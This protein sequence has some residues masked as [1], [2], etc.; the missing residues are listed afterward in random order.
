MMA[1]DPSIWTIAGPALALGGVLIGLW[2][3]RR[4]EVKKQRLEFAN[5]QLRD[6]Y[7]PILAVRKR[8]RTLSEL[9]VE[10]TNVAQ[11]SSYEYPEAQSG[12]EAYTQGQQHRQRVDDLNKVLSF[13]DDQFK[14]TLLPLY[15]LMEKNF[16]EKMHLAETSTQQHYAELI[17]YVE[18]MTRYFADDGLPKEVLA[19]MGIEEKVLHPLY[20]D[21]EKHFGR[22]QD[23]LT[24]ADPDHS[25]SWWWCFSGRRG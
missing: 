21:L 14:T 1:D 18:L 6:F 20:E 23:I 13:Y 9:R 5:Q 16:R 4:N 7:S 25:M 11:P 3:S 24:A 22:L 8:I 2:W 15:E 10:V 12:A 19:R 17:R